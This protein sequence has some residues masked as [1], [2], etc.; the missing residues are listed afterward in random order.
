VR[1]RHAGSERA[2]CQDMERPRAS[3]TATVRLGTATQGEGGLAGIVSKDAAS[4][5]CGGLPPVRLEVLGRGHRLEHVGCV[6]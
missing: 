4:E 6:P 1:G 5:R 3:S 2:R